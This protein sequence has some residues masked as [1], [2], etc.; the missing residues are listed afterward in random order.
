MAAFCPPTWCCVLVEKQQ[1]T[2]AHSGSQK[3]DL[4]KGGLLKPRA[5]Q[6]TLSLNAVACVLPFNRLFLLV[7]CGVSISLDKS[8][9]TIGITEV[10][11][12]LGSQTSFSRPT[13]DVRVLRWRLRLTHQGL[14]EPRG[15]ATVPPLAAALLKPAARSK[16]LPSRFFF[17]LGDARFKCS[18]TKYQGEQADKG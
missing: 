14:A 7:C 16:E 12:L 9:S 17:F 2:P 5:S 8:Y 18:S 1:R 11:K 3:Y 4:A 6:T 10:G 15:H 13:Y